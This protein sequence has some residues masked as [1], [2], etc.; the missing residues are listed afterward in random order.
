[1]K[2]CLTIVLAVAISVGIASNTEIVA[3]TQVNGSVSYVTGGYAYSVQ[4]GYVDDIE[5][6]QVIT[7]PEY[8]IRTKGDTRTD[9]TVSHS[10]GKSTTVSAT[11]SIKIPIK[12]LVSKIEANIGGSISR[13]TTSTQ[14]HQFYVY[15]N[16]KSGW[17]YYDFVLVGT[18]YKLIS[19]YETETRTGARK[20]ITSSW[21]QEI[22]YMPGTYSKPGYQK[23][24]N[25]TYPSEYTIG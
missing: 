11:A 6:R 10:K 15:R 13:T 20:N 14:T 22:K 2:K 8:H 1:M 3:G 23:G 9:F 17:Y 12:Q 4:Y 19:A 18:S 7:D 21:K 24:Y 16:D 5:K 25:K